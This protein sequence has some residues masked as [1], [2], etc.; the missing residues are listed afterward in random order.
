MLACIVEHCHFCTW[1]VLR[2]ACTALNSAVA[3]EVERQALSWMNLH[4][5]LFQ[6]PVANV[7]YITSGICF[8][9]RKGV[10]AYVYDEHSLFTG[11]LSDLSVGVEELEPDA[12]YDEDNIRALLLS[13]DGSV[14]GPVSTDFGWSIEYVFDRQACSK[15]AASLF[16]DILAFFALSTCVRRYLSRGR[17]GMGHNLSFVKCKRCCFWPS[18]RPP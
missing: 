7:D 1:L 12:P 2:Q 4:C 9:A 10:L 14:N 8:D 3:E 18:P 13:G 5:A 17:R 6:T 15:D 16:E 11:V